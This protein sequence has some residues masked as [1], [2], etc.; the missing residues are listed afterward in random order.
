VARGRAD[1]QM[2][3][4][5]FGYVEPLPRQRQHRG[6]GVRQQA[7]GR[8]ELA[9][10]SDSRGVDQ[11]HE[12]AE[13]RLALPES[14][15][16]LALARRGGHVGGA[17]PRE[18]RPTCTAACAAMAVALPAS[19]AISWMRGGTPWAAAHASTMAAAWRWCE[20]ATSPNGG[21]ISTSGAS[22]SSNCAIP[23]K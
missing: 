18:R 2:Q 23:T 17:Q 8:A 9:A 6:G 5:A 14:C 10:V 7:T 22:R 4:R 19:T 21:A 20:G 16:L 12:A 13:R 1:G 11:Q 3:R 15:E